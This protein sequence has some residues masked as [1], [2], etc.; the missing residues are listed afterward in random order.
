MF[1]ADAGAAN[2]SKNIPIGFSVP[3]GEIGELAPAESV[4]RV[5][6]ADRSPE[7]SPFEQWVTGKLIARLNREDQD[8]DRRRFQKG[9]R[10]V[11][12]YEGEQNGF[13]GRY[14]NQFYTYDSQDSGDPQRTHNSFRYYSDAI[15]T[16]WVQGR[17]DLKVIPILRDATDD[18]TEAAVRKANQ[19]LDYYESTR[20]TEDFLQ[21]ECKNE[22]FFAGAFRLT[23]WDPGIGQTI[24]RPVFGSARV[25]L[26]PALYRCDSCGQ[27]E[28]AEQASGGR[29]PDCG[30]AVQAEP[31]PSIQVAM[32]TGTEPIKAGDL[33]V[34]QV[35]PL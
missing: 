6:L 9:T 18:H 24:E 29:C 34:E 19:I 23:Y 2:M 25:Q 32:I 8:L 15:T 35:P 27:E 33:R 30:A 10:N 3:G 17:A 28:L 16:Q 26:G 11:K 14:T 7:Q 4:K 1:Q 31:G 21:D 13:F 22:Q 5:R 20:L 12:Y